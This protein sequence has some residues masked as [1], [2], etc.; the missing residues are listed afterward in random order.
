[1]KK[2]SIYSLII[3]AILFPTMAWAIRQ[4]DQK[5]PVSAVKLGDLS[6]IAAQENAVPQPIQ[7]QAG[8][9]LQTP[10][11]GGASWDRFKQK[12][13]RWD[14]RWNGKSR[15]PHLAVGQPVAIANRPLGRDNIEETCRDFVRSNQDLMGAA[16]HNLRKIQAIKA[17]GRWYAAFEQTHEGVPVMG[18]M[19]RMSFTKD[20]RL[21]AF[22]SDVYPDVNIDTTPEI[23][24]G[25]AADAA[26]WDSLHDANEIDSISDPQLCIMPLS[27]GSGNGYVLCWRVD[28]L[29][30]GIQKK[31]QY[32]VDARTGEMMGRRNILWYDNA[33]GTVRGPYKPEFASDPNTVSPFVHQQV[34]AE[35]EEIVIGSWDLN[36][37]PGWLREGKWAF[38]EP[39][40]GGSHCGDPASGA[41]GT[42][43]FG[44]NLTGD[45]DDM[46]TVKYLTTT[47]VNCTGYGNVRLKFKRWLGV[48]EA[49]YD[50]V[51]IEV[52]NNGWAWT[53]VWE[54]TG[55]SICDGK[56]MPVEYDISAVADNQ[57]A[58]FIRWGMGPTDYSLTFPGWNIDD[59]QVVSVQGSTKSALTQAGG[60]YTVELPWAS[61]RIVSRLTG[62]YASVYTDKYENARFEYGPVTNG[63]T[64]D[65]IWDGNS[66][67]IID[68]P[69]AFYHINRIHDY[70]KVLDPAF[71]GMDYSV[72]T[73]VYQNFSNA[74]WDGQNIVFGRGDGV[75]YDDF[76]LYSEVIYHEYTHGVTDKI[77]TG[78][79]LPY[80]LEAGA[81]NEGWSDYFGCLLSPSQSPLVGDGGLVIGE[82]AGFR[83]LSNNYRR[84]VDWANE[85]HADSQ[86]FSGALWEARTAIGPEVMDQLVHFARYSHANTFEDYLTA[87]LLEDDIRYG[88]SD[89]SNGSPHA[90]AIFDAFGRHGIGGLQYAPG[91]IVISDTKRRGDSRLEPGDKARLSLTLTNGWADA[92]NIRATLTTDDPNV[93]IIKR[94]ADFAGCDF[95]G[96]TD[97]A[98]DPFIIQVRRD[99]PETSTLRFTL[100]IAA[101]GPYRYSRKCLIYCNVATKQLAHDDGEPDGYM[102]M[103]NSGTGMAVKVTPD[104]Y[105]CY[106]TAVRIW[107]GIWSTTIDVTVWAENPDGTPGAAIGTVKAHPPLL[108]DWCDVDVSQLGL[109]IKSGSLF[110]GWTERTVPYSN[111]FDYDP[112]YSQDSW[113]LYGF[114]YGWENFD[115]SGYLGNIMARLRYQDSPPLRILEPFQ[116]TLCPGRNARSCL[117]T[118][119]KDDDHRLTWT[120]QPLPPDYSDG[121]MGSSLFT[122]S[123][124]PRN[125]HYDDK[126]FSYT[127]PF[128]FPFYGTS[129]T[130]VYVSTNGILSFADP[131][132]YYENVPA[133]VIDDVCIAPLYDDLITLKPYDIYID[134]SIPGQVTIRWAA[135]IYW[136]GTPANFAAVLFSD[137]R[138]RF[139]YGSGNTRLTPSVGISA[140][141]GKR[142]IFVDGYDSPMALKSLT[143]APSV[144]FTPMPERPSL[145]PGVTLNSRTGCLYGR[146]TKEGD[147]VATIVATDNSHPPQVARRDITF[148][149]G[150]KPT[151][152]NHD[153]R[154]DFQDYTIMA[155][156][157]S[158]IYCSPANNWCDGADIDRSGNVNWKDMST[159]WQDWLREQ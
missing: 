75:N 23:S 86:M 95:G 48:E 63:Q 139:D 40:G 133:L 135:G 53:R 44:Y 32:L 35:G 87:L 129:R 51:S 134:E 143:N 2:R 132:P 117:K 27:G 123:G 64:V 119:S 56:W 130:S 105:P 88:D 109:V 118:N 3:V 157:W 31:W 85:V 16:P 92:G 156:E 8:Q 19:V 106:P 50:H 140:G 18:S 66:F 79:Y 69:H 124:L 15:T 26:A 104:K 45:Y 121:I 127:M 113:L 62:P 112:P 94:S 81:M 90:K 9:L 154:T 145:P 158:G 33:Y 116:Y 78:F 107:P 13:G 42:N 71:T 29:Q 153:C 114:G 138:I 55:D 1:M 43:V 101:D 110:V 128:A 20:D 147:Y 98:S 137:G 146:P 70:Y 142:Y 61:S 93:R 115:Q 141:D 126:A 24:A 17:G 4:P 60:Q 65:W 30:S 6:P 76:A 99:C 49:R 151:D 144:L 57:P 96:T 103:G 39:N 36:T 136:G 28:I 54:N 73:Y 100:A 38:G 102:F 22:G 149:V 84:E 159:F 77:Y 150:Y 125:F 11:A 14:A 120:A 91:S 59:I 41:T 83:T 67:G 131:A 111:G 46:M 21:I 152:M 58:V 97:N 122:A 7:L 72:P 52:S 25:E 108:N 12:A 148:T 37:D 47:P 10:A 80:A 5:S 89:L 74:Y 82:P 34:D 68:E 155:S